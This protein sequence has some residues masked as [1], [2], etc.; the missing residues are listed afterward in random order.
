MVDHPSDVVCGCFIWFSFNASD[1]VD[2]RSNANTY[3]HEMDSHL[4]DIIVDEENTFLVDL[5]KWDFTSTAWIGL[6]KAKEDV[7]ECDNR[8]CAGE[9][10]TWLGNASINSS[11]SSNMSTKW[12]SNEPTGGSSCAVLEWTGGW[13]GSACSDEYNYICEKSLVVNSTIATQSTTMTYDKE[14]F[15]ENMTP[16]ITAIILGVLLLGCIAS[17]VLVIIRK[18]RNPNPGPQKPS[19]ESEP[20]H[21][22]TESI[23]IGE[24]NTHVYETPVSNEGCVN[25]NSKSEENVQGPEYENTNVLNDQNNVYDEIDVNTMI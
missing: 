14:V 25:I 13:W 19:A 18:Q 3:C 17:L 7:D 10:W 6:W 8:Y 22:Y 24:M 15:P 1:N 11:R 9:K 16:T 23:P 5:L 4:A 12:E 2:T 21:Q 20:T